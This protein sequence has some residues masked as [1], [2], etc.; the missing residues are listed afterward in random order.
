MFFIFYFRLLDLAFG[1][2]SLEARDLDK[3]IREERSRYLVAELICKV[4]KQF[5]LLSTKSS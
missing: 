1:M 3:K 2:P 5:F 4:R